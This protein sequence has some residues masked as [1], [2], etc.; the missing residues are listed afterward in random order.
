[1]GKTGSNVKMFFFLVKMV[2]KHSEVHDLCPPGC[3]CFC[4]IRFLDNNN[5]NS[6]QFLHDHNFDLLSVFNNNPH[7]TMKASQLFSDTTFAHFI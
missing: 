3:L 5:N 4:M 1:M 7:E 6:I 2:Q